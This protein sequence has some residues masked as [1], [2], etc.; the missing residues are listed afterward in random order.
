MEGLRVNLIQDSREEVT[1]GSL[2]GPALLPFEGAVF[3]TTYRILFKGTPCDPLGGCILGF[4]NDDAAHFASVQ[5]IFASVVTH[6]LLS[7][8][9]MSMG[10]LK[11]CPNF[12][13][14][15][16]TKK[17]FSVALYHEYCSV[18]N[19]VTAVHIMMIAENYPVNMKLHTCTL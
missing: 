10:C 15:K 1:G 18:E 11:T 14:L 19:K 8:A 2:G 3:L 16:G 4:G 7:H 17:I 5:E 12:H 6:L 9:I 13:F